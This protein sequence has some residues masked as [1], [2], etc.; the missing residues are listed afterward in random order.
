MNISENTNDG[1]TFGSSPL[2][3]VG[4]SSQVQH[5]S[6]LLNL[7]LLSGTKTSLFVSYNNFTS[8]TGLVFFRTDRLQK[9]CKV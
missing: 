1:T 4:F 2:N 8:I 6:S 7:F 9:L 3:S 5:E